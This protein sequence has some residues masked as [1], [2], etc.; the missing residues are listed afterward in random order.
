MAMSELKIM[1]SNK[2]INEII[3]DRIIQ[4]SSE[5]KELKILEAGCGRGWH[6]DLGSTRYTLTG[7]DMDESA[8]NAR[9]SIK[10]DMD[11]IILGDIRYANLPESCY[12]IIYSS[13]V[14]EHIEG[15]ELVL[16]NFLQW[17]KPGGAYYS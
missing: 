8:L 1:K 16:N 14:L 17:L 12:D 9:K 7:I 13:Y 11:E 4:Q 10:N 15:A 6:Y 5:N 2:V 3:R